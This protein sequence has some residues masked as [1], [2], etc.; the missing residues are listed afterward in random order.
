MDL[1][2]AICSNGAR[3]Q[4]VGH[5][6]GDYATS[7]SPEQEPTRW[8]RHTPTMGSTLG[9]RQMATRLRG[10]SC[11]GEASWSPGVLTR[12]GDVAT[13]IISLTIFAESCKFGLWSRHQDSTARYGANR[14]WLITV[15]VR[16]AGNGFSR[17][18]H[19]R[20]PYDPKSCHFW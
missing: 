11:L 2:M 6:C 5:F 3:P 4:E 14:P 16:A 17:R 1:G 8:G 12:G 13:L 10:E 15:E 18:F 9:G 19:R 7:L 20:F